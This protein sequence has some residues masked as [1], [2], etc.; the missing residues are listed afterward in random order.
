MSMAIENDPPTLEQTRD[1]AESAE[2]F[3]TLISLEQPEHFIT[4][5]AGMNNSLWMACAC[6]ELVVGS[7]RTWDL[8][9]QQPV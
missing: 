2:V 1:A 6:G 8:H 5:M 7:Q 9:R 3:G 4:A